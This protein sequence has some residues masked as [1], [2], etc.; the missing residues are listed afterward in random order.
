[1]KATRLEWPTSVDIKLVDYEYTKKVSE[2]I[3]DTLLY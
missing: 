3:S 1:M 2:V